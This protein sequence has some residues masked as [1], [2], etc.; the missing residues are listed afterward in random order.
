[1]CLQ[2]KPALVRTDSCFANRFIC[3]LFLICYVIPHL[4][5]CFTLNKV[6]TEAYEKQVKMYEVK[7]NHLNLNST[8]NKK[9]YIKVN[10][11]SPFLSGIL[12]DKYECTHMLQKVF[13][14]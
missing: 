10:Y 13:E 6:Q 14:I 7:R 12:L 2:R 9:Y 1:M 4:A 11:C 3:Q 5:K 8:S